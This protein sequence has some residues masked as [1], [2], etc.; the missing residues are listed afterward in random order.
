[1]VVGAPPEEWAKTPYP[2]DLRVS[3][4]KGIKWEDTECQI[5]NSRQHW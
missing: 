1:M 4:W 2:E 3:I 5:K